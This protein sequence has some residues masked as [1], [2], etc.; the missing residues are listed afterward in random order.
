MA[1]RVPPHG[2]A[3][4]HHFFQTERLRSFSGIEI[5]DELM[6]PSQI[7]TRLTSKITNKMI[8]GVL[9]M[10]LAFALLSPDSDAD[11]DFA[12]SEL[13]ILSAV[14]G[15]PAGAGPRLDRLCDCD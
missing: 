1:R 3:F 13:S 9:L 14:H 4:F 2:Q 6:E 11:A 12:A 8:V 10:I 7:G 15:A 5:N